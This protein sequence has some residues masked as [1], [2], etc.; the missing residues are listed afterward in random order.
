MTISRSGLVG[1]GVLCLGC[2]LMIWNDSLQYKQD[3][4]LSIPD[5]TDRSITVPTKGDAAGRTQIQSG[6]TLAAY[7]GNGQ[8]T[9]VDWQAALDSI[10]NLPY[11]QRGQAQVDW[12]GSNVTQMPPEQIPEFVDFLKL[13]CGDAAYQTSL[14]RCVGIMMEAAP[15][16]VVDWM[17]RTG[18]STDNKSLLQTMGYKLLHFGEEEAL[19]LINKHKNDSL[20]FKYLLEGYM[21]SMTSSTKSM[22]YLA[23]IL[24]E[25]GYDKNG[26]AWV[27]LGRKLIQEDGPQTLLTSIFE[28]KQ[29][30][31]GERELLHYA[32][33]AF[34][35]A[36]IVGAADYCSSLAKTGDT[37]AKYLATEV[38]GEWFRN[39]PRALS[40]WV[41]ALPKGAIK[42]TA[43]EQLALNLAQTT[44]N[45]G[46]EW[47]I[48]ISNSKLRD[49]TVKTIYQKWLK[50]SPAEAEAWRLQH[51]PAPSPTKVAD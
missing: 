40:E 43:S 37:R 51:P 47:A 28:S 19:T 48:S 31:G 8:Q 2:S 39:E 9:T 46:L 32:G 30:W 6:L 1:L 36:D 35:K 45:D 27:T 4:L 7:S 16:A 33:D 10:R 25:S 34:A 42:D 41:Q 44:P 21:S 23:N 50:E 38:V 49:Q 22:N 26:S 20:K 24:R 18:G 11:E 13:S 15:T 3:R 12:I 14:G 5:A 29:S 17:A